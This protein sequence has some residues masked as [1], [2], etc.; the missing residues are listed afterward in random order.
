[1][2]SI[3]KYH[4]LH[5]KIYFLFVNYS[6]IKLGNNQNICIHTKYYLPDPETEPVSLALAVGSYF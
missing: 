3:L 1:M 4:I 5:A 2:Y 6:S